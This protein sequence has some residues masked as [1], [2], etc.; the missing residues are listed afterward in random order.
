MKQQA[1]E[2]LRETDVLGLEKP[3]NQTKPRN[4]KSNAGFL[5]LTLILLMAIAA[6]SYYFK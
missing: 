6:A 5:I 4:R 2:I 1:P 3:K